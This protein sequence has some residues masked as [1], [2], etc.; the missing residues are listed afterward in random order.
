LRAAAPNQRF[1]LTVMPQQGASVFNYGAYQRRGV[2]TYLPQSYGETYATKFDPQAIVNTLVR[3]GIPLNQIQPVLAPGQNYGGG[4]ASYYA[5]D[6]YGR[7][8]P[9]SAAAAPAAPAL[10]LPTSAADLHRVVVR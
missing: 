10:P 5:L 2:D 4:P 9:A 6:D 8:V 7:N 1:G 3:S